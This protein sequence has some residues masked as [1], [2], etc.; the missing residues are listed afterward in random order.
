MCQPEPNGNR[1]PVPP[2]AHLTEADIRRYVAGAVSVGTD[3]HVR[4]C[5]NCALRLADAAWRSVRWERRGLLG[6]LVKIDIPQVID[7]L[8]AEI[9]EEQRRDAA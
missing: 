4:I 5:P 1:P 3:R 9:A 6:R 7:E 8:L 2:F